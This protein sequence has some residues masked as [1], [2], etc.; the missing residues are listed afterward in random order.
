[1]YSR[2]GLGSMGRQRGNVM[3]KQNY[4]MYEGGEEGSRSIESRASKKSGAGSK[5]VKSIKN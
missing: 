5:K 3:I 4:R 2:S 1:M